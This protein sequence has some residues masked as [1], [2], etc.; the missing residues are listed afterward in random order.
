MSAVGA[1]INQKIFSAQGA[2]FQPVMAI[3]PYIREKGAYS[4]RRY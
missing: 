4:D 3:L 2:I 1:K